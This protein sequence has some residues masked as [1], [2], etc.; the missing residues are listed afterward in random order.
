[1]VEIGKDDIFQIDDYSETI[2]FLVGEVSNKHLGGKKPDSIDKL[3]TEMDL[4]EDETESGEME[5]A[6]ENTDEEKDEIINYHNDYI[7]NIDDKLQAVDQHIDTIYSDDVTDEEAEEAADQLEIIA[8]KFTAYM[9]DQDPKSENVQIYH[10]IR[11][12]FVDLLVES[13]ELDIERSEEHTS[14]LQ[15]RGH[16]VCRLLLEKTN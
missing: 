9:S 12:A 10:E 6:L 15:S 16:L 8:E 7:E 1:M 2:G 5:L 11:F 3:M 13:I 14:E 4:S